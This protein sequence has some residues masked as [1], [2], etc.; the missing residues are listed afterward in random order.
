VPDYNPYTIRRCRDC[1]IAS[2]KKSLAKAFIPE[3]DLCQACKLVHSCIETGQCTVD[4]I[5]GERLKISTTADK[6]ELKENRR[7]AYA[8]LSSFP[9]MEILINRHQIMYKHKNP[10]Y[11]INGLIADR[12]G[13]KSLNGISNGFTKAKKQ[14][15]SAV[16]IDLDMNMKNSKFSFKQLASKIKWRQNDFELGIIE[17]CYV[18]FN[19]KAA[20]ISLEHISS[21]NGVLDELEKLKL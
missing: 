17:E 3:S 12:K 2:G 8:L 4:P 20:R 7:G 14:G 1:D 16:V 9:N 21:E 10:E 5:Y 18:I 15:C 6:T 19:G 11:T 13:I